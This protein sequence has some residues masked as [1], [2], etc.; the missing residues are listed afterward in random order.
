MARNIAADSTEAWRAVLIL[1]SVNPDGETETVTVYEGIYNS[2]GAAKGRVTY[3]KN[4]T[5]F[6]IE[7]EMSHGQFLVKG[8]TE[9]ATL[10]W[11]QPSPE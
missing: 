8:W 5:K 11:A 9:K 2:E 10:E 6:K 7:N 3:W 4:W 1:N